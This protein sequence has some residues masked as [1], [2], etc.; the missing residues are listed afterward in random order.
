MNKPEGFLCKGCKKRF[1]T[2]DLCKIH[3]KSCKDYQIRKFKTICWILGILLILAVSTNGTLRGE[4]EVNEEK[5]NCVQDCLDDFSPDVSCEI[6]TS[7]SYAEFYELECVDE[8]SWC[9]EDCL[10]Y[11]F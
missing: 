4:K 7:S 9:V 2:Y 6:I 1:D 11:T 10:P 5:V 8:F 3:K